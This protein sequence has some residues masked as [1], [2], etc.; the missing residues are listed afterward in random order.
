MQA[1]GGI[2]LKTNSPIGYFTIQHL[3]EIFGVGTL[4]TIVPIIRIT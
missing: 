4:I 2:H 3:W 1:G